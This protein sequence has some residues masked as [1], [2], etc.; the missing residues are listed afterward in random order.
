M[1]QWIYTLLQ[2]SAPHK[3]ATVCRLTANL[4]TTLCSKKG[5]DHCDHQLW[6]QSVCQNVLMLLLIPTTALQG[7]YVSIHHKENEAQ[8]D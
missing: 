8:T 7:I 4:P 1:I 2:A 3:I 6:M 5:N